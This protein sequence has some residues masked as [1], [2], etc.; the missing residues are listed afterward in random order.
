MTAY[1]CVR[2]RNFI[3]AAPDLSFTGAA[4]APITIDL[5]KYLLQGAN[6]LDLTVIE[7]QGFQG[8]FRLNFFATVQPVYG[9]LLPSLTGTGWHYYAYAGYVGPDEFTYVL[10]DGT[11]NS[12]FA[13]ITID[14]LKGL[15]CEI[16]V[17]KADSKPYWQLTG[18]TG[19]IPY[20]RGHG[21][22][23]AVTNKVVDPKTKLSSTVIVTPEIPGIYALITYT[24]IL[25]VPKLIASDQPYIYLEYRQL[26]TSLLKYDPDTALPSID[27]LKDT[28]DWLKFVW[29]DPAL[30]GYLP[31]SIQPYIQPAGPFQFI[32]KI[33]MYDVALYDNVLDPVTK[34][35]I[36]KTFN[37]WKVH[38]KIEVAVES[39]NGVN[40]YKN[41]AVV[42]IADSA[43]NYPRAP[44]YP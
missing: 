4:N 44:W 40:W 34:K 8:A 20:N 26:Q 11:Q 43:A 24:W 32:L 37:D 28:T 21:G 17:Y 6:P 5:K 41:A 22:K 35:I 36:S 7:S 19:V 30:A 15:T 3:A 2:W 18:S 31:N 33:D 29:P 13:T 27:L 1:A 23:K 16:K 38:E 14:V 12:N 10:N 42:K 25:V 9:T 39:A